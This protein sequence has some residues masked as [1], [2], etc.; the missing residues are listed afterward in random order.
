MLKSNRRGGETA[1]QPKPDGELY[2]FVK[3]PGSQFVGIHSLEEIRRDLDEG[4]FDPQWLGTENPGGRTYG[5]IHTE[6]QGPWKTLSVLLGREPAAPP[7]EE[8]QPDDPQ[9]D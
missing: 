3:T 1:G 5:P 6:H 7:A 2:Y 8:S 9:P 4:K